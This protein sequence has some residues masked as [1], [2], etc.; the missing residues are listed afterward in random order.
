MNTTRRSFPFQRCHNQTMDLQATIKPIR[1]I[2][3]HARAKSRPEEI[4][5]RHALNEGWFSDSLAWLLDP[6]GSH[7]LK[8]GFLKRFVERVDRQRSGPK[9]TIKRAVNRLTTGQAPAPRNYASR[10]NLENA[11]SLREFFLPATT[12]KRKGHR[13]RF[14]DVVVL[15]LDQEDSFLMVIENKLFGS[16]SKGQL[17]DEFEAVDQKY[18]NV[19]NVDFVYLTLR[20]DPPRRGT[21]AEQAVLHRWANLSWQDDVLGILEELV[22]RAEPRMRELIVVLRWLRSLSLAAAEQCQDVRVFEKRFVRAGSNSLL[23]E[24]RMLSEGKPGHWEPVSQGERSA[25]FRHSRAR[26]RSLIIT[27]L[28]DCSLAVESKK[29]KKPQCEKILIPFGAPPDQT[30]HLIRLT[31]RDVFRAHFDK[32]NAFFFRFDGADCRESEP[33]G[34]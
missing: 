24:L 32:P 9:Q 4:T 7:G 6:A 30:A 5:L 23:E 18:C 8:D 25:R 3:S 19:R 10:L 20:G 16:N 15:D 21:K 28:S 31:A 29:G 33:P 34:G 11:T 26:T 17:L 1:E 13:A 22:K 2:L 27:M 14:A 12:S